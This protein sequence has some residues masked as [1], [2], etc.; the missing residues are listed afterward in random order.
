M[1]NHKR[2][3]IDD[4]MRMNGIESQQR[5]LMEILREIGFKDPY[6]ELEKQKGNFSKMLSGERPLRADFVAPMEKLLHTSLYEIVSGNK[7]SMKFQNKGIRYAAFTDNISEYEQ[8]SKEDALK[9]F[10]E[11][12]QSALD[13]IFSYHAINGLRFIAKEDKLQLDFNGRYMTGEVTL[14]GDLKMAPL[15]VLDLVCE[16]GD[17]E[18][19]N[20][21]FAPFTR[22]GTSGGQKGMLAEE[23]S[24]RMILRSE[25]VF[26]GLLANQEIKL[27]VVNYGLVNDKD[28]GFFVNPLLFDLANFALQREKE[29][30]SQ[31]KEILEYG[32]EANNQSKSFVEEHFGDV[33]G[34]KVSEEGLITLGRTIYG[35][36]LTT[37]LVSQPDLSEASFKML[38][39]LNKGINELTFKSKPILGGFS[40]SDVRVENG[41]L[42]K[43]S[44]GNKAEYDF[45]KLMKDRNVPWVPRLEKQED[46]LDYFT[47]FTGAVPGSIKKESTTRLTSI[48]KALRMINDVSKEKLGNGKVY[49]HDDFSVMN[50]TFD[51]EKLVGIIDWDTTKIGEEYEDLIYLMWTGL[52]IGDYLRDD[53]TIINGMKELLKAYG[54]NQEFKK[55]WASKIESVMD[56]RLA[57]TNKD[58]P[59]YR[60]IFNWIGWSKVFVALNHEKIE[61][62][63]G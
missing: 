47:Y 46:G 28:A 14:S 57:R 10:D 60:R 40:K 55:G 37:K 59:S 34:L 51:G 18:L 50:M 54:A 26:K 24:M 58:D 32:I 63:I 53:E 17:A 6:P 4:L 42:V 49:V 31:V 22:M 1:N 48:V 38:N 36:L 21:I 45:L 27:N 23:S 56:G 8:L 41:L 13:Y 35:S 9:N 16:K 25:N 52:N 30:P 5:L 61:K 15:N 39:E 33:D 62:E 43:K 12:D 29:F 2:L 20:S 7:V 44:T 3:D 19:F 11:Y